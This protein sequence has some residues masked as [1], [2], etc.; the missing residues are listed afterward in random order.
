MPLRTKIAFLVCSAWF[1]GGPEASFAQCTQTLSVGA[2]VAS[3]VSSA[4]NGATI[5]LNNGDYGSVNFTNISRS[6]FVTVQS[7]SGTGARMQPQV[8]DSRFIRFRN[9]TLTDAV[10]GSCSTNIEIWN[11]VFAP[12][13]GGLVYNYGS[14]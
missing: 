14:S 2:N 12:N 9:M 6:G 3:A 4:S 5:C 7:T 13:D 11:S 1:L 10:V 8:N